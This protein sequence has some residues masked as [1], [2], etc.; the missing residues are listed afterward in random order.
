[1][2]S[3]T[4]NQLRKL[5]FEFTALAVPGVELEIFF[6]W[7]NIINVGAFDTVFLSNIIALRYTEGMQVCGNRGVSF[8]ASAF[9]EKLRRD[10]KS[11]GE[12]SKIG[13]CSV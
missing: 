7:C 12:F 5:A 10:K 11:K 2:N 9:A 6:N 3:N 8:E 1:M 4:T 13:S